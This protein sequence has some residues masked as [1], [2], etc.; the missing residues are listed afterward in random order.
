MVHENAV[1][2][3]PI[4]TAA[5]IKLQ[6]K[7]VLLLLLILFVT[8]NIVAAIA[9]TFTILMLGRVISALCHGAFFG[10]A[11]VLAAE[12]AGPGKVATAISMILSGLTLANVIGVPL[13][14][15]LGNHFGWRSLFWA[16]TALGMIGLNGIF[17][18]VPQRKNARQPN[19]KHEFAMLQRSRVLLSLLITAMGFGGVFAAFTYIAPLLTEISGFSQSVV[20][21]LLILFGVGLMVGNFIG[22]KLGDKKLIPALFISLSSLAFILFIFTFT[23]HSK[24]GAVIT[25]FIFGIFG[26]TVVSPLQLQAV[27]EAREAPSLASAMNVGAFNAGIAAGAYL[28]GLAIHLGYG[29]KSPLV[30]GGLFAIA[31]IV[32]QIVMITFI[33]KSTCSQ[34]YRTD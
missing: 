4:L 30:V 21:G 27:E 31:A 17:W 14:T 1:V 25:L 26:F 19:I 15:F 22:G 16:I 23:A 9:P 34:P 3:A 12:L 13:G 28:A 10:I 29:Y 20:A 32:L 18:L 2:S 5:T 7:T 11:T 6:R 8:G 24:I 33:P